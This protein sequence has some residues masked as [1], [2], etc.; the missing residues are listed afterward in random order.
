MSLRA[1]LGTCKGRSFAAYWDTAIIRLFVDT[2]RRLAE[3]TGLAVDDLDT[4]TRLPWC[5]GRATAAFMPIWSED[6]SGAPLPTRAWPSPSTSPPVRPRAAWL[7]YSTNHIEQTGGGVRYGLGRRRMAT[8]V[9]KTGC[10]MMAETNTNWLRCHDCG[11]TVVL[12]PRL[13]RRP[14]TRRAHSMPALLRQDAC[15]HR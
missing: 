13:S 1:L 7:A 11:A 10:T 6:W 15:S 3:M 5:S 14:R 9:R 2:G 12:V 4:D 8:Q